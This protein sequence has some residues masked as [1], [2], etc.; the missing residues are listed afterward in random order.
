[1]MEK[2]T[3]H[4]IVTTEL[5]RLA[6]WL[7]LLG[8]DTTITNSN[9]VA[10][11]ARICALQNRI[12]LTRMKKNEKLSLIKTMLKIESD[13][14]AEQLR[15]V[16]SEFNLNQFNIFSRCLYCNRTVYPIAKNKIL[17]RLP[18]KVKNREEHYT[19]CRKCGRIYWKGTHF[20]NMLQ[21]LDSTLDGITSKNIR[22]FVLTEFR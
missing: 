11:L 17:P 21:F 19:C 7:R 2:T 20:E 4:F 12:L 6:R 13:A 1:M 15:Q 8:Y 9:D 10:T 3:C 14:Y 18:E 22:E 5:S 16:I